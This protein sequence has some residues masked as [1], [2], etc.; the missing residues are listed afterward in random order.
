MPI[1]T[2]WGGESPEEDM[3]PCPSPTSPL[4]T[5]PPLPPLSI[6]PFQSFERY[7]R[8]TR[9]CQHIFY[10]SDNIDFNLP[11][12]AEPDGMPSAAWSDRIQDVHEF[13]KSQ[14]PDRFACVHQQRIHIHNEHNTIFTIPAI[15]YANFNRQD[16]TL[17]IEVHLQAQAPYLTAFPNSTINQLV[18]MT[19][20]GLNQGD[21]VV[22]N[23][24]NMLFAVY[25]RLHTLVE[26]ERAEKRELLCLDWTQ[27]INDSWEV[28]KTKY[29]Y[30][31]DYGWLQYRSGSTL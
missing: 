18:M 9:P 8:D 24:A 30:P 28:S 1:F 25:Y 2:G 3:S 4:I 13:R 6:P 7:L 26:K 31:P 10:S 21:S 12:G 17:D 27:R 15:L 16:I 20:A 23:I 14:N 29:F 5:P 19:I 11:T 22:N